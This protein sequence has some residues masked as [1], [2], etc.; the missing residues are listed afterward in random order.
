MSD[1]SKKLGSLSPEQ[2]RELRRRLPQ[3][4]ADIS[5]DTADDGSPS[6]EPGDADGNPRR[7]KFSLLFFSGQGDTKA[8][9]KYHLAIESSRFADQHEFSAVWTPERHFQAFGGLFPNP[10]VLGAALA[11]LT[12]RIEIRAGSVVLPLHNVIRVAEEW[13]VVDN[14]SNGRVGL[15]FATG[16]H[17][18][19]FI[20]APHNYAHRKDLLFDRVEEFRR[21]WSGAYV[22]YPG[23][24]GKPVSVTVL[25][26]PTRSD[27]PIWITSSSSPSTWTKAG[28]H[29]Y[30]VLSGIQGI[31][32]HAL[33]DLREK[34]R[35]YRGARTQAGHAPEAGIVS[36]ML[37]TYIGESL[38][39]VRAAV[40]E[41]LTDYVKTF[42]AQES[43]LTTQTTRLL[44]ASVSDSD[45]E[46]LVSQ[47]IDR[48]LTNG[49]LLGT[50][51]TA[52]A[53]LRRLAAMGVDEIACFIDFGLDDQAVLDSL[54]RLERLRR[55]FDVEP[56]TPVVSDTAPSH[57]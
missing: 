48:L 45:R 37:H 5:L 35:L 11:V 51:Q 12:Q 39:A 50:E 15:A 2:L 6:A 3:Q 4:P 16:Y 23:V 47:A 36:L 29:G 32:E 30:N 20:L 24:D 57:E 9:N 42:I 13:A 41:P 33:A 40:R 43:S 53:M 28:V 14:L 38:A 44:D 31:R 18:G 26:R 21:L 56:E 1:L 46:V 22:E 49:S 25:P 17:P 34:I 52:A 54:T 8:R 19:D 55:Q 10:S 27:V 7:L